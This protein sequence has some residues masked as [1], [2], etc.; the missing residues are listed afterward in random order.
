MPLA[1]TTRRALL[2]VALAAI[3]AAALAPARTQT[4]NPAAQQPAPPPQATPSPSPV[5]LNV[6]VT[7]ER[8]RPVTDL[9]QEDFRVAEDGAPQTIDF[10]G[11]AR[12]PLSYVLLVDNSGSLR[13]LIP[14]VIETALSF[15]V[16]NAE[17]D[18]GSVVRFVA[19]DNI[20]L[21]Q[22]FTPERR[23][24]ERALHG[25]YVEGGQTAL[26]DAV[27]VAVQH[28][29][30]RR[31]DEPNRVRAVV[32]FTDG[33]ER[34]STVSRDELLTL[35]RRTGVQ[36]FPVGY[37]NL[38]SREGSFIRRPPREQAVKL[39]E[40]MASE[41]GGRAFFPKNNS[42]LPLAVADIAETLRKQYTL[43]YTPTNA[44]QDGAFR[45]LKVTLAE[46]AAGRG[47]LNVSARAG[48]KA[49]GHTDGEKR[50]RAE[51][52]MDRIEREMKEAKKKQQSKPR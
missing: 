17:G 28:V 51:A 33:E 12:Q 42:E 11:S 39:L 31:P 23:L 27:Y 52:E 21:V 20:T 47:K 45:K 10:F 1:R 2:P 38:L 41:S 22:D 30:K 4:T 18:E 40:T 49:P 15:V 46:T 43:G 19:N 25:L 35:L 13:Q 34:G 5:R 44:A 7:D 9:K 16:N 14:F 29:E 50:K 26:L 48:Y 36:V 32:V 24:L 8:G 6:S 37:V 3:F